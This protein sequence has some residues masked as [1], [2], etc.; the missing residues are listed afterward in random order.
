MWLGVKEENGGGEALVLK[1]K[2]GPFK[3]KQH[4]SKK[5][6]NSKMEVGDVRKVGIIGCG[7]MGPTVA[8]AVAPKYPVIVKEL[9]KKLADKGLQSISY[10]L[11]QLVRRSR[12]TEVQKE[13]ALS[14]VTM[15]TGLADLKDC[16]V[17]IDA[18]PDM[19]DLKISN[20]A[21]LNKMC[22]PDAVFM[23]TSSLISIT[24]LAAG[25]GR[26]EKVIGTHFNNPAHLMELVEVAPAVQTSEETTSFVMSFIKDGLGKT[27]I[28]CKDSPGFIV[29]YL[30]FPWLVRAIKALEMGLGTVEDIDTA[31]RLGLGHRMGPFELMDMFGMHNNAHSFQK[32]YEQLHD[33]GYAPPPRLIKLFE[34]GHLGRMTGKGWYVYDEQGKKIGVNEMF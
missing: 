3:T 31:V 17:V 24:A 10:G 13:I 26:P 14:Q 5:E 32:I 16:Q 4:P 34:A 19:M 18:V 2:M 22:S 29:N 8:A 33:E 21:E 12:I 11:S 28:K 15:T 25:S 30:L 7:V 1:L 23:T 20:F 27:P 9:N 6:V